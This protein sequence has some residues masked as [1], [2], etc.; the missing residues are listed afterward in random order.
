[1]YQ[2]TM[3]IFASL[4]VFSACASAIQLPAEGKVFS[5]T[6]EQ[7]AYDSQI[8]QLAEAQPKSEAKPS[9]K[10]AVDL[11]YVCPMHEDVQ[12]DKPGKCPKCGMKLQNRDKKDH[13]EGGHEHH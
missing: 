3:F 12:S 7:P 6:T 8:L 2:F 11:P 5:A 4:T 1:M 13:K 10:T 9:T